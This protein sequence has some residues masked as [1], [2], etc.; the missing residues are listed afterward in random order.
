MHAHVYIYTFIDIGISIFL[1]L[2]T[3]SVH[4]FLELVLLFYPSEAPLRIV[5]YEVVA[6]INSVILLTKVSV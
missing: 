5:P 2:F 4:L 3:L 6:V 1:E